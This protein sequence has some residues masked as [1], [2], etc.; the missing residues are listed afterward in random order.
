M[1][2]SGF[3]NVFSPEFHLFLLVDKKELD[4]TVVYGVKH[5]CCPLWFPLSSYSRV[6][7]SFNHL[8][9][10]STNTQIGA[11][12]YNIFSKFLNQI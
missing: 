8:L 1:R 7:H 3:V 11:S 9:N 5:H 10:K 4:N 2:L 6:L 12:G